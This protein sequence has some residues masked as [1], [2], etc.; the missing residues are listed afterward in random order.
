[1]EATVILLFVQRVTFTF[2]FLLYRLARTMANLNFSSSFSYSF[3]AA[4]GWCYCFGF[5]ALHSH[6][7]R[8]RKKKKKQNR[9]KS[10]IRDRWRC[11]LFTARCTSCM[12]NATCGVCIQDTNMIWFELFFSTFS[13]WLCRAFEN[14]VANNATGGVAIWMNA[15]QKL[16][17]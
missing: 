5:N 1:M 6:G 11:S 13:L 15:Q 14:V 9:K 2:F 4:L 10:G 3:S 12:R 8:C 16:I 7:V 17:L